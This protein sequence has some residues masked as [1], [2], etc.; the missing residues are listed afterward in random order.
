M[1]LLLS[2]YEN[3]NPDSYRNAQKFSLLT[4]SLMQCCCYYRNL[5]SLTPTHTGM[6]KKCSLL[7]WSL[8]Q[9]CCYYWHQKS[10]ILTHIWMHKKA[11]NSHDP[12]CNAAVAIEIWKVDPD[13]YRNVPKVQLT[14]M[15][16]DAM[17]LLL[18]ESEKLIPTPTGMHKSAAYSHD[19]WCNAAVA[20]A[21]TAAADGAG[22]L[23]EAA[24]GHATCTHVL[25]YRSRIPE[26]RCFRS[27]FN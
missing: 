26:Y 8:M 6:Y 9:C 14:H 23:T 21:G 12:W 25:V 13:S 20:H 27:G 16:L 1:L 7:T 24:R 18:S 3:F 11:A 2:E 4:W 10:L 17:L 5:N 19:P 15:I 22:C